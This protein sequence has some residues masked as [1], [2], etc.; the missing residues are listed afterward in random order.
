[1]GI[2]II[3]PID[4]IFGSSENYP[5]GESVF[6]AVDDVAGTK[7]LNFDRLNTGFTVN[8][9][10]AGIVKYLTLITAN[11]A[12]ERDPFTY[13]LEGSNDFGGTYTVLGQGSLNTPTTRFA[14]F[15]VPVTASETYTQ[16]R[17]TFP[18]IRNANIANSMQV[19]EAALSTQQDIT[20]AADSVSVTLP[21]GAFTAGT[22][23]PEKLFDNITS[24]KLDV[25]D[26]LTGS[27][28]VDLRPAAGVTIV[29]AMSVFGGNDDQ[30]F[31]GRTPS[32]I[33]LLGSDDGVNFTSLIA[34]T[35]Q[36]NSLNMQEQTFEFP[37]TTP[38]SQYRI[39]FGAPFFDT[40]M[41]IGEVQLF[42]DVTPP[43]ND[44][45]GSARVIDGPGIVTGTTTLATG[46][47]VTAC[48]SGDSADVWFRYTPAAATR[49]RLSTCGSALDTTL[50]V[51]T[52]CGG[53]AS[54]CDDDGCGQNSLVEFDAAGGQAYLIRVASIG[55]SGPFRLNVEELAAAHA[56]ASVALAY[57]FNGLAHPGEEGQPD[58]PNGYRAAADRALAIT[59]ASDSFGRGGVVGRSEIPYQIV[60][61]ANRLDIVYMG[62]RNT[63]ANGIRAF[64]LK[65]DGDDNGVQPDWLPEVDQT[66]P[67]TTD[68]SGM[69]LAMGADT[70]IG[71]LY[72]VT[73]GGGA[74]ETVLSFADSTSMIV[75]LQA[76]DWFFNPLPAAPAL[77]VESQVQQGVF[78]GVQA[79]DRAEPGAPLNVVE[80]VVSTQS[81]IAG[82]IGDPTGKTLSSITFQNRSNAGGAYI[83]IAATIRDGAE[84]GPVCRA[85]FNGDMFVNSQDFFDFIVAFFAQA[86][87]ADFNN[88]TFVN[89]QDFFDFVVAFFAGC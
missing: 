50:A 30:G 77:G 8:P 74:F 53:S 34:A 70:K 37:N 27:T 73:N 15:S 35:P 81:L 11:D 62:N 84:G 44:E 19:A 59:S 54:A 78:A 52:S 24:T 58:A 80:A 76:P 6:A 49:L 65:A 12:T 23:G 18:T 82:G 20:S 47:D 41:Q 25:Q 9:S 79:T 71:F 5:A 31:P 17:L 2:D 61:E 48:G 33:E 45:C 43:N 16:Y 39:V 32:S 56:D 3:S 42:G 36:Q 69:N 46:S 55:A 60:R 51:Y 89:S 85:D 13:L 68:V 21:K 83:V 88:D 75:S 10:G 26:A 4:P 67:K 7:Y 28:I 1:M 40:D 57:N 86:P 14:I 63:V 66:G 64:D 29:T 87:S 38:Y 22:E 72:Q